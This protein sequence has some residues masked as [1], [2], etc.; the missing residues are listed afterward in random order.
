MRI[1]VTKKGK[2]EFSGISSPNH[3][4]QLPPINNQP[5]RAESPMTKLP[6]PSS[7]HSI[8]ERTET[9]RCC[10]YSELGKMLEQ[11]KEIE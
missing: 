10:T 9:R 4:L 6:T 3:I 7:N 2:V 11:L 8:E 5:K 1:V